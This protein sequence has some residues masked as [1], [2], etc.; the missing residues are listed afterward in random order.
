VTDTR[1]GDPVKNDKKRK[2]FDHSTSIEMALLFGKLHETTGSNGKPIRYMGG[3]LQA[4]VQASR[5]KVYSSTPDAD[6]FMDDI[7]D[8][9][10]YE[11]EAA[12]D[13]RIIYAGN[14]ALNT[15]NKIA[16]AEL[17]KQS[18][19]VVKLYGMNL[20]RWVTP[21]GTFFLKNHPLLNVHPNFRASLWITDPSGITYCPLRDTDF[22]DNIQGNDEDREKGQWLTEGTFEYRCLECMKFLG[23]VV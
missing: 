18:M 20:V 1:T 4:L 10:N 19:E 9:F 23:N 17:T 16:A 8:V 15:I 13:E 5:V 21:Q 2:S 3:L 6:T 12:G 7:Y 11:S 22:K 14:V